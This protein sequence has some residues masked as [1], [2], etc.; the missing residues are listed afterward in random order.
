MS[1][2]AKQ[3]Y[4]KYTHRTFLKTTNYIDDNDELQASVST[5]QNRD[6]DTSDIIIEGLHYQVIFNNYAD[7]VYSIPDLIRALDEFPD[8]TLI[9]GNPGIGKTTFCKALG[10]K[11]AKKLLLNN[12]ILVFVVLLRESEVQN[13]SCLDQLIQVY[14]NSKDPAY[15][16]LSKSCAR[17]LANT[18]GENILLVFDGLDEITESCPVYS[19]LKKIINRSTLR[20]CKIIITSRPIAMI[21][22]KLLQE[23]DEFANVTILG[24]TKDS[25]QKY[26]ETRLQNQ[27][28]K[29]ELIDGALKENDRLNELC[30]I[31]FVMRMLASIVEENNTLPKKLNL[32]ELYDGY[33][34]II[35]S[36]LIRSNSHDEQLQYTKYTSIK[37]LPKTYLDRLLELAKFAF[38]AL[39]TDEIIFSLQRIKDCCPS[40][41]KDPSRQIGLDLLNINNDE[42]VDRHVCFEFLHFSIQEFLAA[43]YVA[44]FGDTQQVYLL[45]KWFFSTRYFN[46]WVM[47][48][49]INLSKENGYI[50]DHFL[51][52][53]IFLNISWL[54]GNSVIAKS[55]KNSKFKS[56]HTLQF[57]YEI[58]DTTD[59]VNVLDKAFIDK[60][61]IDFSQQEL[62]H[63]NI[64]A[65]AYHLKKLSKKHWKKLNL[66]CCKITDDK[67]YLLNNLFSNIDDHQLCFDSIDFSC[68]QITRSSFPAVIDL[69]IKWNIQSLH[70]SMIKI[71]DSNCNIG[72]LFAKYGLNTSYNHH[73]LLIKTKNYD[74]L[75]LAKADMSYFLEKYTH[76]P[77]SVV[78]S[79]HLIDCEINTDVLKLIEN[80]S[81]GSRCSLVGI[82]L[83]NTR[84]KDKEL[85]ILNN[86][87][88]SKRFKWLYVYEPEFVSK[89][90]TFKITP[91]LWNYCVIIRTKKSLYIQKA[92]CKDIENF[93]TS[94]SSTNLFSIR[95][96]NIYLINSYLNQDNMDGLLKYINDNTTF[97]NLYTF[98]NANMSPAA[99]K[100]IIYETRK[101]QLLCELNVYE[102]DMLFTTKSTDEIYSVINVPTIF[103]D[104]YAIRGYAATSNQVTDALKLNQSIKKLLLCKCDLRHGDTMMKLCSFVRDSQLEEF[105]ILET[106][107][108]ESE[109]QQI[110]NV[111]SQTLTL[112]KININNFDTQVINQIVTQIAYNI[113]TTNFK[114]SEKLQE[115]EELALAFDRLITDTHHLTSQDDK[116]NVLLDCDFD[117]MKSVVQRTNKL[118]DE[119]Q[120]LSNFSQNESAKQRIETAIKNNDFEPLI[121]H[122]NKLKCQFDNIH[123]AYHEFQYSVKAT[124]KFLSK[125]SN[126]YER[127]SK[128]Q[129]AIIATWSKIFAL[130]KRFQ[131]WQVIGSLFRSCNERMVEPRINQADISKMLCKKHNSEIS[132]LIENAKYLEHAYECLRQTMKRSLDNFDS[133]VR[134]IKRTSHNQNYYYRYREGI[135]MPH[136]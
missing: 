19:F 24:L 132:K 45:D 10:H 47:Y 75:I 64:T 30:C 106:N 85:K 115:L 52:G 48:Y 88:P 61:T 27:A 18:N 16:E 14:Y 21:T 49:Y 136:D 93:F 32:A 62:T 99:V 121:L 11:W 38:N 34:A 26:F 126:I 131:D 95:L 130:F 107:L 5:Y 17:Y 122:A 59:R 103:V 15:E 87:L 33:I 44:S 80:A 36:R 84:I 74:H 129:S 41:A 134:D 100:K 20:N 119:L 104:K 98:C 101:H 70:L 43:F 42:T 135:L 94:I 116:Y 91:N 3:L 13:I 65:I 39:E 54:V 111:L 69:T 28:T 58:K 8:L 110:R 63:N 7:V 127:N 22:S 53:S 133:M 108:N 25:R 82:Q 109:F 96:Q 97:A 120:K 4:K 57:L 102:V 31:P 66:K 71:D 105:H 128:K 72:F 113:L 77:I 9:N 86:I 60:S 112:R 51:S 78:T 114:F 125:A 76:N 40:F 89:E 23:A 1:E 81:R 56:L 50:L 68:N 92:T 117:E 6:L 124:L 37:N 2:V 29:L 55:I 67:L 35:I 12:Q 73:P 123:I 90:Q 46:T 79:I 118:K 83:C